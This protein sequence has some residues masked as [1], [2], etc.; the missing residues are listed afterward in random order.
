MKLTDRELAD[1]WIAEMQEAELTPDEMLGVLKLARLKYEKMRVDDF[2]NKY[3]VEIVAKE[4]PDG[5][6]KYRVHGHSST[7]ADSVI[8]AMNNYLK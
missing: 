2:E 4:F 8:E 5:T 1:K 3:N 7:E 6:V